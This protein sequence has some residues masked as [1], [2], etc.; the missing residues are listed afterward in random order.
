M[1]AST[2]FYLPHSA[3]FNNVMDRRRRLKAHAAHE[4][5]LASCAV[6]LAAKFYL[7][8][9][10]MTTTIVVVVALTGGFVVGRTKDLGH[11]G[12]SRSRELPWRNISNKAS[13]G[14]PVSRSF[15]SKLHISTFGEPVEPA[16][17][18]HRNFERPS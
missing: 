13:N 11:G 17:H 2:K 8:A 1:Q 7:Q 4:E 12:N 6:A 3:N 9:L 10:V 5:R 16:A 14:W 18:H 15:F